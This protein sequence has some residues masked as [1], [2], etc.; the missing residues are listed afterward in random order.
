LTVIGT[1]SAGTVNN[2]FLA[3]YSG[4][5]GAL[6]WVRQSGGPGGGAAFGIAVDNAGYVYT[7]G[8]SAD[9]GGYESI[10]VDK[11]TPTGGLLWSQQFAQLPNYNGGWLQGNSVK[12]DRQGNVY[13]TGELEYTVKFGSITL[14]ALGN[15]GNATFFLKLDS[16]GTVIWAQEPTYFVQTFYNSGN[17]IAVDNV[18]NTFVVGT[19]VQTN[20]FGTNVLSTPDYELISGFIA[21]IDPNGNYLWAKQNPWYDSKNFGVTADTNGNV[22]V[23]GFLSP[24][25]VYITKYDG[26]GNVLWTLAPDH[27][28]EHYSQGLGLSVDASNRVSLVTWSTGSISFDNFSFTNIGGNDIFIGQLSGEI[29][30]IFLIQPGNLGALVGHTVGFYCTTKSLYPV[31][32]QWQLFGTNIVGATNALLTITNAQMTDAGPYQ[33]I[34]SNLYGFSKSDVANLKVYVRVNIF[35]DHAGNVILTWPTNATGFTLQSTTNLASSVWTTNLPSPVVV[36]GRNTV[37]NPISSIQQFYRL[38]R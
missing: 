32:Y 9:F 24:S 3:K 33:V 19:F 1:L 34:A 2:Q 22:Y 6:I 35:E 11:W 7:T 38:S 5:N 37:T 31:T 28:F 23:T 18:G 4:S 17:S 30:P 21:K 14:S 20:L 36:S 12:V 15:F 10:T 29:P 27:D 26:D 8:D 16:N 13:V 25:Q